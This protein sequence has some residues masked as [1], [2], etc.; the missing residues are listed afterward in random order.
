MDIIA[1]L[2]GL[3]VVVAILFYALRLMK[4]INDHRCLFCC[5]EQCFLI[6]YFNP[7]A[8][9]AR[10]VQCMGLHDGSEE[11]EAELFL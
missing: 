11:M 5:C 2:R 6:P 10:F 1:A 7:H 3:E 9:A 4:E 8:A